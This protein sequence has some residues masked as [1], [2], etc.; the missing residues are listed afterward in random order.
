VKVETMVLE[1]AQIDVKPGMEN[2]FEAGVREAA[3]LFRRAKGC[4][5]M[6]LQRS[7]ERPTRYRLF[8]T[9][10]TVESHTVDFRGSAD[11]QEWRKLV[12]RCFAQPP[13]VEHTN[14]VVK[15]F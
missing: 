2:E 8:V 6:E 4:K 13:E 9:W 1:I 10:E 15:G 14:Q 7:V 11:F 3:P 5:G 12:G